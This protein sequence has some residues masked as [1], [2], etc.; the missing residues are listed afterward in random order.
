MR[1]KS[2]R[3]GLTPALI[4]FTCWKKTNVTDNLKFRDKTNAKIM[5]SVMITFMSK[6]KKLSEP[7]DRDL[8][9]I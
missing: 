9:S 1:V 2:R 8:E 5:F 6:V 4:L 3:T 7:K